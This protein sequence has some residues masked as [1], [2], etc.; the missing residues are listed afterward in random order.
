MKFISLAFKVS[1]WLI[2]AIACFAAAE[3]FPEWRIGF[4]ILGGTQIVGIPVAIWKG[5]AA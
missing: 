2:V 3:W 1:L 5:K 4:Y